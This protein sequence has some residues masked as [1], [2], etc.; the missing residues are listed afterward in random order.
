VGSASA[1][2]AHGPRR[3]SRREDRQ[4]LLRLR[5]EREAQALDAHEIEA[6]WKAALWAAI[7][8]IAHIAA[9]AFG[10][11]FY[12]A[13]FFLLTSIAYGLMLPLIAVLHV[14]HLVVRQSGAMLGT[15][16]GTAVVVV[17]ISASASPEL[18]VA[19]LFVRAI[20][21]WTIGKMWWETGVLPRWLG[22]VTLGL[23]AGEFALVL[24]LAPLGADMAVAW[25][26][27]RALL[28]VWLLALSVALWRTR[29]P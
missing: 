29:T 21:W 25:L 24:A 20:W 27:L 28:G 7:A 5:R 22:A 13:W 18:A 4:G 26:P 16:G 3:S 19:A 9:V 12:P 11:G 17:G 1:T 6:T 2:Q 15:I 10:P 14:R 23:A 8:G